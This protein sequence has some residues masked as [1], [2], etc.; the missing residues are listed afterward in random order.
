[1]TQAT[2]APV[3]EPLP[4]PQS[5][6]STAP[7]AAAPAAAAPRHDRMRALDGLRIVA[8]LMVCLYHY[9]GRGGDITRAWGESPRHLFPDLSGLTVYGCLGVQVFFVISGFVICMSSWGR[10]LG[11][12]FRSRVT[13]LY[14][15]YWAA[16]VLVTAACFA[17]PSVS[18]PLRLHEVL[19]N[20]T[21]LQ[22]PMGVRRVLGVCWTL[23]V[24]AR[25]YFFLA[26]FVVWKGVTYR[27]VVV[28]AVVW[29]AATAFAQVADNSLVTE[30]VMQDNAP[31]FIG[32]LALYLIHRYGSDILLWSLVGVSWLLGQHYATIA[33]WNPATDPSQ[34][35]APRSPYV[36]LAIVTFAFASVAV[37]ALGWARWANWRWLT[38]AGTLTYPFYLVH[39]HLGWFAVTILHKKF[40][41]DPRLTLIAA[42]VSMLVL[43]WLIHRLVEKPFGPKLRR[44]MKLQAA[45]LKAA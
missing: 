42:I 36:I 45:R 26:L 20:F 29:T 38:F 8:A 33:L 14:P 9:S 27:R 11:D 32:G 30:L 13:R 1:M 15:A 37:V 16:I 34:V 4:E 10:S 5:S 17:L 7:G 6:P 28:F 25:F 22:Q 2:L 23:W 31:F 43:A 12:F 35:F 18:E 39:E 40:G 41:L 24:E 44:A 3:P 21:M 19:V